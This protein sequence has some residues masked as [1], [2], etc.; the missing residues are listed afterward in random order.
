MDPKYYHYSPVLDLYKSNAIQ[1]A[2]DLC[3][4]EAVINLLKNAKTEGEISRIMTNA[5]KGYY[6]K[7]EKK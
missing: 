4:G 6:D 5:R 2:K 3:Y 1:A 7:R